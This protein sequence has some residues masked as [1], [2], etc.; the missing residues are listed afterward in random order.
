MAYT[1]GTSANYNQLL[2]DLDAWLVGT[3]GWTQ[4]QFTTGLS[5]WAVAVVI[6]GGGT[7]YAVDDVL[8][9]SGGT[10][11]V[12]TTLTVT[13]V[14]GGVIDG[15]EITERGAYTATP[16]NP[17]SVTGGTGSGA[18]FNMTWALL[19]EQSIRA[20]WEADGAGTG[21]H[22]FLNMQN[23]YDVGN[24]FYSWKIYG[25]TAWDSDEAD[26][27]GAQPGA[28]GPTYFNLWQNEIEYWFYGNDRRVI[29]IAKCST[30]YMSMYGGFFLPY[31]E[32]SEYPFPHCIIASYPDIQKPDYN[33]ARNSMIADPGANGAAWYR[34]RTTE[35]WWPIEN[36]ANSTASIAPSTGQRAFMWP[37]KTGRTQSSG[38][39]AEY[40]GP[41]GFH[42]MKLNYND[43]SPLIPC[44]IIDLDD[45]TVVGAL[46]GVF[47]TC[48]FN[49]ST[50]QLVTVGSRSFR[51]FQRAFR[52]QAGDFFAVEEV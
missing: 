16:S 29:V 15:I 22:M 45:L 30:N 42:A 8:T 50:E 13:S 26:D 5:D 2:E 25:A 21:K 32:P 1:T 47:S 52:N 41:N 51:L 27:F 33:N 39:G 7:G 38:T 46:E 11:T 24:G 40:W 17:V 12:Q 4:R 49:R 44:Q 9:V 43:E 34:R 37:H 10:Y 20:S 19:P 23:E 48:G 36:Q 14:S 31:S 28:G 18:T 6:A 35:T 3:V